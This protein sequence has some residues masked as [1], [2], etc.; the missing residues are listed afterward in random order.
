MGGVDVDAELV[1][2]DCELEVGWLA[3]VLVP[4]AGG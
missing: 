2:F 1:D 4:A 3:F